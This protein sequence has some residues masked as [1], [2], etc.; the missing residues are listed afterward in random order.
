MDLVV[1]GVQ[2]AAMCS[3]QDKGS[4]DTNI[5]TN[6][7]KLGYEESSGVWA[8]EMPGLP[9]E[10]VYQPQQAMMLKFANRPNQ[11]VENTNIDD[12]EELDSE[13]RL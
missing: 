1:I 9:Q 10:V 8:F 2:L 7:R 4:L 13:L 11:L 6:L 12:Q 5:N 3:L